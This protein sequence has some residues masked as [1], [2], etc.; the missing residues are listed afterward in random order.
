MCSKNA[1][2]WAVLHSGQRR[3]GRKRDPVVLS[4]SVTHVTDHRRFIGSTLAVREILPDSPSHR[5]VALFDSHWL[6]ASRRRRHR[7]TI[8]NTRLA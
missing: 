8:R 2:Q 3:V 5:V 7:G 6:A 4:K 1:S